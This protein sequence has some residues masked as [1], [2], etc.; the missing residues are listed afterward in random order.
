MCDAK[1]WGHMHIISGKC[2]PERDHHD[3]VTED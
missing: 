1:D 2:T 3:R